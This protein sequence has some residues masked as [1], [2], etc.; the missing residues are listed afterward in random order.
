MQYEEDNCYT[1][2]SFDINSNLP[3]YLCESGLDDLYRIYGNVFVY[4]ENSDGTWGTLSDNSPFCIVNNL[5]MESDDNV[6]HI[7]T[8][9]DFVIVDKDDYGLANDDPVYIKVKY[10]GNS[11]INGFEVDNKP[12]GAVQSQR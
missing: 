9:T 7:S 4:I 6:Y 3:D 8:Q 1:R 2:L 10:S 12:R 5:E 11:I